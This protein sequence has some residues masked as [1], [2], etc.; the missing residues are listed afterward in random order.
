MRY[1]GNKTRL[2]DEIH[3]FSKQHRVDGQSL[4]DCFAGT[5]VVAAHFKSHGY[6]AIGCDLLMASYV[7]QVALLEVSEEPSFEGLL[8]SRECQRSMASKS[9][10]EQLKQQLDD[11]PLSRVMAYLSH[12]V[13]PEQGLI[14]RNYA[15]GGPHS[16]RYF[17]D[18]HAQTIDGLLSRLND[19]YQA[20]K[21]QRKE[22]FLL[23]NMVLESADRV[24]NIAG[25]YAAYLKAWQS[26]TQGPFVLRRPRI[27]PGPVGEALR[28]DAMEHLDRVACDVLYLDPPYNTRQYAAYY[29]VREVMAELHAIDDLKAYEAALYGKTGLR[30]YDHLKSQFCQRRRRKGRQACEHAFLELLERARA[31][32]VIISY[33]EEGIIPKDVIFEAL[34][35]FSG[36]TVRDLKKMHRPVLSRRFRSDADGRNGRRY[37]VLKGKKPGQVDEWLFYAQARPKARAPKCPGRRRFPI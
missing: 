6:R 15:P 10:K 5:A 7:A 8:R 23:L 22:F 9:F 35:K 36:R 16:R 34:A 24:A 28:G 27:V 13:T 19:W 1:L 18:H 33:N 32:H 3:R 25:V 4:F 17:R 11:G 2:L 12:S 14:F 29:H 37:K 26:N 20:G 30:P 31:K 21:L